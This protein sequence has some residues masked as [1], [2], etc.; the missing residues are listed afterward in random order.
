MNLGNISKT[1]STKMQS[2]SFRNVDEFLEFLP[3][4]ELKIALFLRK[5]IF[6]CG[7]HITEKLSYN[8]PYYKINKNICF[9]WPASILWGK[10]KSYDG[11]RMG[12]TAGYLLNDELGYLDQGN[13]KQVSYKDFKSLQEIDLDILKV[14]IYEALK[15]DEQFKK[16]L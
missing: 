9:I 8:V 16:K 2:V 3:A 13:R 1:N 5:I 4:D 10:T 6:N 11:V 12:F 14:Y 15:V 7:P